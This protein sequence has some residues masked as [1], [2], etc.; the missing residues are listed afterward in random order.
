[1]HD[2]YD[3]GHEEKAYVQ[4]LRLARP[5]TGSKLTIELPAPMLLEHIP[6]FIHK[7]FKGWIPLFSEI[8][9]L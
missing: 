6:H 4:T 9:P 8:H 1:M 7:Y 3:Y 2:E 5:N